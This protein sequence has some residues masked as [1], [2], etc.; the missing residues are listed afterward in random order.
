MALVREERYGLIGRPQ[1]L[2]PL[3]KKFTS[4]TLAMPHERTTVNYVITASALAHAFKL[5]YRKG[6]FVPFSWIAPGELSLKLEGWDPA[7]AVNG[8]ESATSIIESH[9]FGVVTLRAAPADMRAIRCLS[10]AS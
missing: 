8:V 7:H 4:L 10:T 6:Y 9:V 5:R 1:H 2:R 3:L